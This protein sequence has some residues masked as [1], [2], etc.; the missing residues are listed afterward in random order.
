[1]VQMPSRASAT[2]TPLRR[3]ETSSNTAR[4]P[5]VERRDE[6]RALL[7]DLLEHLFLARPALLTRARRSASTAFCS[8]ASSASARLSGGR[9]IVGLEHPLEDLVFERLD[10][11]LR[12][13]DLLLHR[14]VL[15]VGLH[16]HE[17]IAELRQPALVDGH[18]LLDRAAGVLVVG[19]PLLRG[20]DALAGGLEA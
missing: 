10:L 3:F 8:D 4:T 16:R 18:V 19:E 1:M 6:L 5:R 14:L 9:Q 11:V 20:G 13:L 7:G 17:L 2:A 12:E 15:D